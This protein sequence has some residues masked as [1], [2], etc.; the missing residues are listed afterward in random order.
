MG[1]EFSLE[2]DPQHLLKVWLNE[3]LR[4]GGRGCAA[5]LARNLGVSSGT[6]SKMRQLS[7]DKERRRIDAQHIPI[8]AQFFNEAPPGFD[9][10]VS[11]ST[12]AP[13]KM[14]LD[15]QILSHAIRLTELLALEENLAV[16]PTEKAQAVAALYDSLIESGNLTEKHLRS[17]ARVSLFEAVTSR[18]K[19]P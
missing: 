6:I 5:M 9:G 1:M 12:A 13:T 18:G 2:E 11:V 4:S 10:K 3:K 14:K 19:N 8:L 16:S 15:R 7:P 17:A